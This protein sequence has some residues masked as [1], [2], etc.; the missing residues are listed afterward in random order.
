MQ[1]LTYSDV[2]EIFSLGFCQELSMFGALTQPC[3]EFLLN[4]GKINKYDKG[5][6]VFAPGEDSNQFYVVLTGRVSFSR[7]KG[8]QRIYIRG[9][10][11]GE[12]IGFVGMI[13]LHE[14]RG[15]AVAEE[16]TFLL[17]IASELFHQIC[18]KFSADFVVF[19]INITR[20]MSREINDLDA[21][22]TELNAAEKVPF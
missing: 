9:F 15:F 1:C 13:G 22:C 6:T 2:S 4:E 10:K 5:E 8:D 18:D 19:L 7:P 12:Q 14:R 11:P 3:L 20:E 21:L 17:E 16:Q